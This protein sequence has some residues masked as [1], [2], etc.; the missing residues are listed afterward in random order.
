MLKD[1][2]LLPKAYKELCLTPLPVK[3]LVLCTLVD[4]SFSGVPPESAPFWICH[5]LVSDPPGIEY[6][7]SFLQLFLVTG[8]FITLSTSSFWYHLNH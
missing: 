3:D 6:L 1:T 4:R 7:S 2:S 8:K 5:C